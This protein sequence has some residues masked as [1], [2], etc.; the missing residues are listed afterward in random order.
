[1]LGLFRMNVNEAIDRLLDVASIVFPEGS[2]D[3]IDPEINT[4]RLKEAVEALVQARNISL[5]TKMNQ[6][7]HGHTTCKVYA[8]INCTSLRI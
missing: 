1:M 2:Q 7:S 6:E 3:T 8:T 5:D 4:K